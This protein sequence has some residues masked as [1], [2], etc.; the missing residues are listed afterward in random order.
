MD[1]RQYL[2]PYPF[3]V[4]GGG[5]L[6]AYLLISRFATWYRLRHFRGPVLARF[7]YLFMLRI[8]RS[9]DHGRRYQKLYEDYDR[10]ELL[11]IGP[12]DLL[13]SSAAMVRH[14][15]SVRSPYLRSSWYRAQRFDPYRDNLFSIKDTGEHDKLKTQLGFG[16]TG[17]D[18]PTI[19]SDV[20]EQLRKL[21]A[22]IKRK[23]ISNDNEYRPMDMGSMAIF[24]A[25]DSISSISFGKAFGNLEDGVD[26][27][28]FEEFAQAASI[29]GSTFSEIPWLGSIF[30]Y[31][32]VLQLLGPKDTDEKGLGMFMR[33]ANE[34]LSKRLGPNGK[35]QK[36]ML[37]SFISRGVSL[38][39]CKAEI[40]F[41]IL[42]GSDTTAHA[43]RATVLSVISSPKVYTKVQAEIDAAI[44]DG[45]I[46]SSPV[47]AEEVKL[48]PY[49]QAVIK[50]GLRF[51]PP[52]TALV[53]KQVPPEGDNFEG[54]YI[55]GGTR[56]S[57]NILAIQRSKEIFGQDP[58]VFRPERWI[59][60]SEEK[61]RD[62]SQTV[63]QVFGWGR[64]QCLGKQIALLELNKVIVELLRHFDFQ[65]VD[66]QQPWKSYDHTLWIISDFWV[67]VTERS[68]Q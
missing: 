68:V 1:V 54:R 14:M 7:S 3:L 39:Q 33:F 48:L 25:V 57:V 2:G 13:T 4:L 59:D 45:R 61:Y 23:Y 42:A 50:E 47:L 52:T 67:R 56:V 30:F 31:P 8:L 46:R 11:R 16:Y 28:E 58:D 20:D 44:A 6:V 36:D 63:D 41:Q 10:E 62:M 49:M 24:F 18:V 66:L 40:I 21:V 26:I 32:P 64:W 9:R 55:P 51:S 43:V 65:V 29:K 53:S 5:L 15:N 12:N 38:E 17:K 35:S 37:G 34:L 22:L 60:I 19:E 27:H